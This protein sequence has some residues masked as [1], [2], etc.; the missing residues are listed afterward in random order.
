MIT[1]SEF[2]RAACA[3]AAL[4][5]PNVLI[6]VILHLLAVATPLYTHARALDLATL[7]FTYNFRMLGITAGYHR[8]LAQFISNLTLLG[9]ASRGAG[10]FFLAKRSSVVGIK[11]STSPSVC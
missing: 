6:M 5:Q 1:S 11:S 3:G 8:L 7:F 2:H 9:L 4:R 10:S